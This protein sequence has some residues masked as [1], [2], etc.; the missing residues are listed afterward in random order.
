LTQPRTQLQ[1]FTPS[2][3]EVQVVQQFTRPGMPGGEI[4]FQVLHE[5]QPEHFTTLNWHIIIAFLEL[6]DGTI[7]PCYRVTRDIG[8]D[9]FTDTIHFWQLKV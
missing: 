1:L 5:A 4:H 7:V 2:S 9:F 3:I 6:N 8:G